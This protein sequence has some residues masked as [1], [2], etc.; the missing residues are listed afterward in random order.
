[1]P[2][3]MSAFFYFV[4]LK[5]VQNISPTLSDPSWTSL[6]PAFIILLSFACLLEPVWTGFGA[7]LGPTMRRV[8]NRGTKMEN[9]ILPPKKHKCAL[10]RAQRTRARYS[11]GLYALQRKPVR[12][13]F[14]RASNRIARMAKLHD[15]NESSVVPPN[16]TRHR[17]EVC[18]F[19]IFFAHFYFCTKCAV[20]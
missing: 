15:H 8:K 16:P 18:S 17:Q 7:G 13:T 10:V 11:G 9:E 19:C 5:L 1:M 12:G 3:T 4:G 20:S 6:C 14:A 2:P